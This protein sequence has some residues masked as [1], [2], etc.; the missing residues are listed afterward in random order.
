MKNTHLLR[1]GGQVEVTMV[2]F[3]VN[4]KCETTGPDENSQS[5]TV[6]SVCL[7]QFP[8]YSIQ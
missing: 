8:D 4:K 1:P 3:R 5:Y 6:C 2:V 7:S